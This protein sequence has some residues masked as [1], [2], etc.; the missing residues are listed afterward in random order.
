MGT[1]SGHLIPHLEFGSLLAFRYDIENI[2]AIFGVQVMRFR[3][4]FKGATK[5][6]GDIGLESDLQWGIGLRI[7]LILIRLDN[8]QT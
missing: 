4:V 1:K 2:G 6:L 7:G 8:K 5:L 3:H